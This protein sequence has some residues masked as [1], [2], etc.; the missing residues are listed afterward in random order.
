MGMAEEENEEII[1][2]EEPIEPVEEEEA[3]EEVNINEI[4]EE[5]EKIIEELVLGGDDEGEDTEDEGEEE[6][7]VVAALDGIDF[8]RDSGCVNC[9]GGSQIEITE[10]SSVGDE[11]IVVEETV[12]QVK[13]KPRIGA[14]G[15]NLIIFSTLLVCF[16]YVCMRR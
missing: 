6:E 1:M 16:V 10:V 9:I 13:Q 15:I 2:T 8:N 7:K 11:S 3:V 4:V 5:E 14:L 12:E